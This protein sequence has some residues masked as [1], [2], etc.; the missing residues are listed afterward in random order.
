MHIQVQCTKCK[1]DHTWEVG[2]CTPKPSC[3]GAFFQ[4]SPTV[5]RAEMDEVNKILAD[6]LLAAM[7]PEQSLADS[8]HEEWSW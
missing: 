5:S 2:L 4:P 1:R 3:C 7:F 8:I 6:Q